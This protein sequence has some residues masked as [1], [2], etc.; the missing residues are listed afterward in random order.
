[1]PEKIIDTLTLGILKSAHTLISLISFDKLCSMAT[2][3]H[4]NTLP[5]LNHFCIIALLPDLEMVSIY[6]IIKFLYYSFI[7][8]LLLLLIYLSFKALVLY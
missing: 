1:M 8:K 2:P 5:L 3:K 7:I 4:L 6:S